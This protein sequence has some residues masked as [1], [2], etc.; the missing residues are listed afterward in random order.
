MPLQVIGRLILYTLV[1]AL[2]LRF[3]IPMGIHHQKL[4]WLAVF[5]V[6]VPAN[7]ALGIG[8]YWAVAHI[9]PLFTRIRPIGSLY[10]KYVERTQRR[11]DRAVDK[12]GE[13]AVAV[14]IG[15]PLPGSGAYTGALAAYLIGLGF[16]KFMIANF[17]GVVVAGVVVTIVSLVGGEVTRTI[18]L[19]H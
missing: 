11:I 6:C 17:V 3:S 10:D 14:F 2:E 16:R 7:I 18:F 15:I 9:V 8:W 4:N 5:A 13:W 1:P 12:Y 19:S